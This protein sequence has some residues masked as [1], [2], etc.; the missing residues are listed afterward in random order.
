MFIL[1]TVGRST[2]YPAVFFNGSLLSFCCF[3]VSVFPG[4][5]VT[6]RNSVW[7]ASL[8]SAL[9]SSEWNKETRMHSAKP[10]DPPESREHFWLLLLDMFKC[11]WMFSVAIR[12]SLRFLPACKKLTA[13]PPPLCNPILKMRHRVLF[14][15]ST[16]Y[17]LGV[18]VCC[19]VLP[20][21]PVYKLLRNSLPPVGW[22]KLFWIWNSSTLHLSAVH[23]LNILVKL[24]QMMVWFAF[25]FE[26]CQLVQFLRSKK[27][28]M[29]WWHQNMRQIYLVVGR[30]ASETCPYVCTYFNFCF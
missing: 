5:T 3:Y 7:T 20:W 15:L 30:H 8:K 21:L 18:F 24:V 29:V 13:I 19:C 22:I 10:T 11:K 25:F 14:L 17:L 26:S 27:A 6:D 4:L 16:F 23:P 12:A 9:R 1:A 2:A 28:V